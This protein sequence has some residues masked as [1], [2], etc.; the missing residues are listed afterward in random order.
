MSPGDLNDLSKAD[1]TALVIRLLGEG[2]ELKR[3]VAPQRDEITRSKGLKGR[4]RLKPSGME[5]ASEAKPGRSEG[6]VG[7][8]GPKA[9][10]PPATAA[11]QGLGKRHPLPGHPPHAQRRHPLRS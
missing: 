11:H 3:T 7:R 5:A 6:K 8:K 9:S 1:L 4:L 2:A 10:P